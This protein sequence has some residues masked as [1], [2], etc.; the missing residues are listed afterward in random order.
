MSRGKIPSPDVRAAMVATYLG[1]GSLRSA[2]A[3]WGL[4]PTA[5]LSALRETGRLPRDRGRRTLPVDAAFFDVIDTEAK[6]YWLGFLTADGFVGQRSVVLILKGED[7]GHVAMFRDA[8]G[9]G[10]AITATTRAAFGGVFA[11][12]RCK[13]TSARLCRALQARGLGRSGNRTVRPWADVPSGLVRHFWR[14]MVDGDGSVGWL[15]AKRG[16]QATIHLCGIEHDVAAFAA[17]LAPA[18]GSSSRPRREPDRDLW[19]VRMGG[20]RVVSRAVRSLYQGA[21]IALSRKAEIARRIM[22][23]R[24]V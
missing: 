3:P 24:N 18:T 19:T 1:G 6:A 22:E 17:F 4:S 11:Q 16:T 9:A 2:A 12:V 10:H 13:V 14:G 5:V 23:A 7:A 20:N 15:R 8:L 21:T